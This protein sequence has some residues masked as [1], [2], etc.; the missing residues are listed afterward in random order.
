VT[1]QR[2]EMPH[3][4]VKAWF[5]TALAPGLYAVTPGTGDGCLRLDPPPTVGPR[6]PARRIEVEI[7]LPDAALH[8]AS[9]SGTD[10]LPA[11]CPVDVERLNDPELEAYALGLPEAD[12][13]GVGPG[14]LSYALVM[15]GVEGMQRAA[16]A[17]ADRARAFLE[18]EVEEAESNGGAGH[19]AEMLDGTFDDDG[20]Y[21]CLMLREDGLD[22]LDGRHRLA[23]LVANDRLGTLAILGIAEGCS[24]A[25]CAGVILSVPGSGYPA[26]PETGSAPGP[27]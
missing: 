18:D 16:F 9:A 17:D 3:A 4:R 19:W 21:P 26:A 5:D 8:A 2:F 13:A 14:D 11:D 1:N 15:V 7:R 20:D 24:L 23:G 12:A 27:R 6:L 10:Y 22:V 25:D